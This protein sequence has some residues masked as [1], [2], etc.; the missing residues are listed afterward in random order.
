M[1]VALLEADLVFELD[2]VVFAETLEAL[3]AV[4]AVLDADLEDLVAALAVLGF[5]LTVF[6]TVVEAFFLVR[7]FVVVAA[8]SISGVTARELMMAWAGSVASLTFWLSNPTTSSTS[9]CVLSS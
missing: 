9:S 8:F 2:V 1:E 6:V 7:R 5:A 4:F 3:V